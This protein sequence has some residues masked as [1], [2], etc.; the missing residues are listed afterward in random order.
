MKTSNTLCAFDDY[1]FDH[2]DYSDAHTINPHIGPHLVFP[3]NLLSCI[4][5]N[6][7]E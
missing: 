7:I 6:I 1:Y 4:A 2:F 5:L 3:L